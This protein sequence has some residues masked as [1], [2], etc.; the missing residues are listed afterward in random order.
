MLAY[1][2]CLNDRPLWQGL[3][4]A[5]STLINV[6]EWLLKRGAQFCFTLGGKGKEASWVTIS[7]WNPRFLV[8]EPISKFRS[9]F[10]FSSLLCSTLISANCLLGFFPT[11]TNSTLPFSHLR[12][13]MFPLA[14]R[15]HG[16]GWGLTICALRYICAWLA[17]RAGED[18]LPKSTA[19]WAMP[20]AVAEFTL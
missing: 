1:L 2:M 17:V 19:C 15:S 5:L 4:P 16:P 18:V 14:H 11:W 20:E 7:A 9:A 8:C 12:L 3:P 10:Q 13:C 6:R